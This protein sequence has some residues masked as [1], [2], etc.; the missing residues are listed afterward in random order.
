MSR[1]DGN[2]NSVLDFKNGMMQWNRDGADGQSL[3]EW[4][5]TP[6]GKEMTGATGGIQGWQG[7]L[8]GKPYLP[9]SWQDKLIE[10]FGGTHDYIGGQVSGLYD[11]QGNIKRGMTTAEKFA[12]ERWSEIAIPVSAPFAAAELLSP[13]VWKAIAIFL[14]AGQ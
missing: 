6:E 4:L 7:T 13:E 10:A 12:H 9:G 8:F 14:R 11:E 2:G 5:E 1:L 3:A